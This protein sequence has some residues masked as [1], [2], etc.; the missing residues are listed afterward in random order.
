MTKDINNVFEAIDG[1]IQDLNDDVNELSRQDILED[2]DDLRLT[3]LHVGYTS[4]EQL[5]ALHLDSLIH[6]LSMGC[7]GKILQAHNDLC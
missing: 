1:Y 3:E 4:I 7:M 5:R 2:N 6:E